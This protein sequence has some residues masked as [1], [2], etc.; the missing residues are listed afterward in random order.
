MHVGVPRLLHGPEIEVDALSVAIAADALVEELPEGPELEI[1]GAV[2]KVCPRFFLG[3][4]LEGHALLLW[5]SNLLVD[6]QKGH[7]LLVYPHVEFVGLLGYPRFLPF[8]DL[9]MPIIQIGRGASPR[10]A[11]SAA[12]PGGNQL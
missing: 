3:A 4:E 1:V 12:A 7:V 9:S 10:R 6:G 5:L 2:G 8:E 11:T